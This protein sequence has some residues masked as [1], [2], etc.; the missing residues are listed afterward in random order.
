MRENEMIQ[1]LKQEVEIP[2]IVKNK[3]NEAFAMIK[4]EA[5]QKKTSRFTHS[6]K[7]K[8][9]SHSGIAAALIAIL[10]AGTFTVGAAA[11][12]IWS[13][14]LLTDMDISNEQQ[15]SLEQNEVVDFVRQTATDAGV[16]ITAVQTVAD[17][18]FAYIA[19]KI[20]GYELPEK[21]EPAINEINIT[22]GGQHVDF[23]GKF[24]DGLVWDADGNVTMADGSEVQY[25]ENSLPIGQYVDENGSLEFICCIN[26]RYLSDYSDPTI[27]G[28]AIHVQFKDL[29][30]YS[31][32][33]KATGDTTTTEVEGC[34]QLSWPLQ[35][36][37]DTYHYDMETALADSGLTLVSADITPVSV[38]VAYRYPAGYP[39][40]SSTFGIRIRMKDGTA[41]Y[42]GGPGNGGSLFPKASIY[43]RQEAFG[44]II[45]PAEVTALIIS[46]PVSTE[47]D[48]QSIQDVEIPINPDSANN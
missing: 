8:L 28:K 6:K 23:S 2:D 43:A 32:D 25:D 7:W 15:S 30:T 19:F 35:G 38:K 13:N 42:P 39:N 47:N 18:N 20:D 5:E 3:A 1:T 45:D 37:K 36:T 24:Y 34:W 29:G 40:S 21:A 17:H 46:V 11:H 31:R 27:I 44:R 16:T 41:F 22:I 10:A 48:K 12:S 4:A 26:A 33:P 14:A 9:I